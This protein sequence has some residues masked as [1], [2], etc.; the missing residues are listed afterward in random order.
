MSSLS[1]HFMDDVVDT[2]R[3]G[4]KAL[5]NDELRIFHKMT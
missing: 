3:I 4:A 5:L 1:R 2:L